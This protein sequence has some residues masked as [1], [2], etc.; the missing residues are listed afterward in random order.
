MGFET[1][2]LVTEPPLRNLGAAG[3]TA[4]QLG[5]SH[6]PLPAL[7]GVRSPSPEW[8]RHTFAS[9]QGAAGRFNHVLHS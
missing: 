2:G 3:W 5:R 4:T 9:I 8:S 7:G 1:V 6:G